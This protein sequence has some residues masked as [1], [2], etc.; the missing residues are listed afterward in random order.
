M[1][2]HDGIDGRKASTQARQPSFGGAG[3]V[4]YRN[5]SP[6]DLDLQLG[7]QQ[8]TQRRLID[9]AVHGMDDRAKRAHFLQR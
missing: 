7:W 1:T 4:S 9:I 6:A 5:G 2:E 3:V 8:A